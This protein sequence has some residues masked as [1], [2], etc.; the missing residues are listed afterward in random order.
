MGGHVSSDGTFLAMCCDG[1]STGWTRQKKSPE[2][3][4][5][6][7]CA[8]P[9]NLAPSTTRVLDLFRDRNDRHGSDQDQHPRSD[10]R[11]RQFLSL[12]AI[13]GLS[14]ILIQSADAQEPDEG[15]NMDVKSGVEHTLGRKPLDFADYAE[16]TAAIGIWEAG[17]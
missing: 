13:P 12:A 2:I 7:K 3:A 1:L 15:S 4:E 9:D 5:H 10:M 6:F 8:N 17:N 14:G 11:R 16:R